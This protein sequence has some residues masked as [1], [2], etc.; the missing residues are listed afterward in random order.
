MEI[1]QVTLTPEESKYIIALSIRE[2]KRI[3]KALEKGRI[4]FKGGSTVSKVCHLLCGE[5]VSVCGVV[6]KRG[7]KMNMDFSVPHVA[8]L[9]GGKFYGIDDTFFRDI[10]NI[11]KD[12]VIICGANAVDNYGNAAMMVGSS[13]GGEVPYALS[14]WYGEGINVMIPAGYE[15]LVPGNINDIIKKT[16][17][18]KKKYSFGMAV[19]LVPLIGEI[20]TEV[21]GIERLAKVKGTVISAGG[22]GEAQGSITMDISGES[23]ELDKIYEIILKTKRMKKDDYNISECKSPNEYCKDHI[24]CIYKRMSGV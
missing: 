11:K 2:D 13:L 21:S 3:K 4:V 17:R 8:I 24:A 12:D 5:K 15:K 23:D 10:K 16:G 20:I 6:S 22:I 19:G 18:L 14:N 1:L 9:E 7:T